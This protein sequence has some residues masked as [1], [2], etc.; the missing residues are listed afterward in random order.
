MREKDRSSEDLLA[1]ILYLVAAKTGLAYNAELLKAGDRFIRKN[2]IR[3]PLSNTALS[4][5]QRFLPP[6]VIRELNF[7]S[8][9]ASGAP[10]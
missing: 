3:W 6:E 2:P 1:A 4:C 9:T 10:D 8:A 7:K 5:R